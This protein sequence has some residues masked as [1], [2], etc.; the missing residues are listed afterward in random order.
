MSRSNPLSRSAPRLG[1]LAFLLAQIPFLNGCLGE[2]V[3]G[4]TSTGNTG[5]GTISGRVLTSEGKGVANAK[6]RV[7]SV[8]HNPGPSGAGFGDVADVAITAADGSFRTDSLANGLYNLLE[9]KDG[10]L[11]FRDSVAVDN[12]SATRVAGDSLRPPGSISGVVRLQPGHDSRTVFLI[13]L[14]TTT[15]G[16]PTDSVGNFRLANLAQGEYRLRLLST[17]DAYRPLDT[18]IT[19]TSG[20]QGILR[21][22]LRLAYQAP[23]GELPIVDDVSIAY[24]TTRISALVTWRKRDPARVAAYFV[25]RKHRD[26]A[27]VRLSKVPVT[28][29][30]FADDWRNG[31]KPGGFY[32]YA[33][34]ALD[35][36]GNEGRKG[37]SALL[38]VVVR[39]SFDV[40]IPG[41]DCAPGKC[42]YDMD[43]AGNVFLSEA[44]GAVF[45]GAN[46]GLATKWADPISLDFGS[47]PIV[48]EPS[49]AAVY[50]MYR[51]PLRIGKVDAAGQKQWV[52][53]L[54]FD[55]DVA[56]TLHQGGDSLYVWAEEE[57]VMTYLDKQ[58]RIL[59]QDTLLQNLNLANLMLYP[60]YKPGIGFYVKS[61][62]GL[63]F[64]DREGRKTSV[65]NPENRGYLW[66]FARDDAGRWYIS[67]STGVLDVFSPDR[68][69]L[70][71]ILEGADGDLLYRKGALY[72]ET[73][74]G[75]I[76]M[77][78]NTG[79]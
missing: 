15:L 23:L 52:T 46:L 3:A 69:L 25:Y 67:W 29:T 50:M 7:V 71:S 27:F 9:E 42:F 45:H 21:D 5:K 63:Q 4:T 11:S 2:Q 76:F 77:R 49:G 33:V 26:S 79:F 59:G 17:L 68:T 57:R 61:A 48:V 64:L 8:D 18:L 10:N 31:L 34:T 6:V 65:W 20:A 16:V 12:D 37:E 60:S 55:R 13:L 43:S 66:D 51:N 56:F 78:I 44:N 75:H 35:A 58:G 30:S 70:G 1:V 22:T 73:L 24:D 72:V 74:N 54:P 32:E 14:G 62:E 36:R 47:K 40:L 53:A 38:R 28:D 39:Y 19:I 41:S